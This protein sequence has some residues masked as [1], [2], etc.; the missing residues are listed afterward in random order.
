[1][2]ER[3]RLFMSHLLIDCLCLTTCTG[4]FTLREMN[5]FSTDIPQR[6]GDSAIGSLRSR[7]GYLAID[8]VFSGNALYLW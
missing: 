6:P 7:L 4:E 1:M 5:H 8:E 2:R 3:A